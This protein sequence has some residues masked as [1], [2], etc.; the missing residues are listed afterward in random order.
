MLDVTLSIDSKEVHAMSVH[1][2]WTAPPTDTD[3]TLRQAEIIAKHIKGL[4]DQPFILAGDFNMPPGSKVIETI[5]SVCKNLTEGIGGQ[6][7]NLNIH[8]FGRDGFFVDHI[9]ASYYFK[10]N[11]VEV[12]NEDV[13]DHLPVV[14]TLEF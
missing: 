5:S 4:D 13:S 1:G 11:S 14:S 8:K 3:E 7:L 6:T 2:P 10:L 9:F 12:L